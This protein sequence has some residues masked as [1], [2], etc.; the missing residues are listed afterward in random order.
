ME[1]WRVTQAVFFGVKILFPLKAH[2]EMGICLLFK[3][4]WY[5]LY[6]VYVLYSPRAIVI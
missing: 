1:G 5:R 3:L 6:T 4:E 2:G